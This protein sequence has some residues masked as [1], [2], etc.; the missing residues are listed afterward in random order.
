M[1]RVSDILFLMQDFS[2]LLSVYGGEKGEFLRRSLASVF[3]QT[4]RAREVVLVE[5]GP[6]TEDL[7]RVVEEFRARQPELKV[8]PLP[9][10]GGLGR[11]LNEG[12]KHCSFDIVAR[13]DT[14]DICRPDR[15]EKQLRV[16]QERPEVAVASAWIDEFVDDPGHVVSTRRLP[17]TPEELYEYG[18]SRCPVNHPV[19]MFRKQAVLE[20]GG[21]VHYPLFEDYYLWARMMVGGAKFYNIQESL[22]WFRTSPDM[23]RRRGGLRYAL[24]EARLQF[25]FVGIG[26]IGLGRFFKNL[27]VRFAV[28]LVPNGLRSWAYRHLLRRGTA[29]A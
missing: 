3:A 26:Y 1:L 15:F 27:A 29:S 25:L 19:V 12:L 21:Y 28:R 16:L 4:V 17:E 24:T 6:L 5:D 2:V 9:V 10:N 20:C 22:L 23:F 18:K 8:V 14:D 7:Y 11:A 13:M